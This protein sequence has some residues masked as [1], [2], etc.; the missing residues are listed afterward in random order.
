MMV[1]HSDG[2]REG[3]VGRDFKTLLEERSVKR[4]D[5]RVTLNKGQEEGIKAILI[6]ACVRLASGGDILEL[7]QHLR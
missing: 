3:T 1:A 2:V 6:G 5:K 7:R 4:A